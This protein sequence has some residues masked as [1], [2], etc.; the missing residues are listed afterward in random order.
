MRLRCSKK[1]VVL[2]TTLVLSL[3]SLLLIAA[4]MKLIFTGAK[5]SGIARR[6]TS[7]LEAAKGGLEDFLV[8]TTF[9]HK[10][11]PLDNDYTC[12]LQN[13]TDKW[14]IS[15]ANYDKCSNCSAGNMSACPCATHSSPKDILD[16]FDWSQTYGSYT[17]YCKIV[18]T[19]GTPNNWLYTIDIVAK[20]PSTPEQA[21][22]TILYLRE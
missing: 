20:G 16:N 4:L 6:Y 2:I 8:N 17:V 1:G 5:L 18:D 15:C 10:G 21:W 9:S 3:V 11:N 13:D 7:A 19:R 12:K 22:T 14:P